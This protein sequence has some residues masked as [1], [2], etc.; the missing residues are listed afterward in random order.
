M[1]TRC[2]FYYSTRLSTLPLSTPSVRG[3]PLRLS[4]AF[5][6]DVLILDFLTA[7][8]TIIQYTAVLEI[9]KFMWG[10]GWG[11]LWVTRGGAGVTSG[12]PEVTSGDLRVTWS[13]L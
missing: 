2:I 1:R 10:G 11:G 12:E 7:G 6:K 4:G 13:G 5:H 9:N 8:K 3:H